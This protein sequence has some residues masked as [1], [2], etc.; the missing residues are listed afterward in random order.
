MQHTY[1]EVTYHRGRPLAAYLYLPR[2]DGARSGRTEQ[3]EEG[4]LVDYSTDGKA[5][6]IEILSPGRLDSTVLNRVLD[7]LGCEPV[8]QEDLAPLEAA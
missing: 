2:E 1:L 6:G 3:A 8:S 5:I 7:R 4:L